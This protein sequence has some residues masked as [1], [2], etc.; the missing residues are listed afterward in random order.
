MLAFNHQQNTE[1]SLEHVAFHQFILAAKMELPSFQGMVKH[2]VFLSH[3]MIIEPTKPGI[4]AEPF[5][6]LDC[7]MLLNLDCLR[8]LA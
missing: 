3:L 5:L 7:R 6:I 1:A 4:E 8:V 2:I